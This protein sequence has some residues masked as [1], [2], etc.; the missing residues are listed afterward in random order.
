MHLLVCH[1][2]SQLGG[3][4]QTDWKRKITKATIQQQIDSILYVSPKALIVVMGDM[5]AEPKDD[6]HRMKNMLWGNQVIGEGTHKYQ[7]IWSY[8]DQFYISESLINKANVQVFFA[9]WLLEE[10][11]KYLGYQPKR[12]YSGYRYKGGYSD[13]LPI[14]LRLAQ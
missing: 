2:P 5:N 13:H 7:G 10:D 12:C 4:L 1:L 6:L 8:L 9:E 11:T 14:L 3:K